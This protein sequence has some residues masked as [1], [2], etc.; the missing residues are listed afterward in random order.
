MLM[1][2]NILFDNLMLVIL[3]LF[4]AVRVYRL[5]VCIRWDG[6]LICTTGW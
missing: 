2:L 1:D 6:I 3:S 4:K 5:K